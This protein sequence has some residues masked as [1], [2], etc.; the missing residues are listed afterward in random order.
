MSR[1]IDDIEAKLNIRDALKEAYQL[2]YQD[3]VQAIAKFAMSS[4]QP[5]VSGVSAEASVG[6]VTVA[7]K[8]TPAKR[9]PSG[10]VKNTVSRT[11]DQVA[12]SGIR[13]RDICDFAKDRFG[14]VIK[15]SSSR[16]ALQRLSDL[17]DAI[18]IDGRWYGSKYAPQKSSPSA[19]ESNVTEGIFNSNNGGQHGAA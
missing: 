15:P 6:A 13:Q 11:L 17:G 10:A 8:A 5:Q 7:T 4:A 2:G 3:A 1:N 9:K 19:N 18:E 16:M 12:A 14:E